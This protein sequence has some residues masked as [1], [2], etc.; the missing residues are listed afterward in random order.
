MLVLRNSCT[1]MYLFSLSLRIFKAFLVVELLSKSF[2]CISCVVRLSE[3]HIEFVFNGQFLF[4]S[5]IA[6]SK[7]KSVERVS[8]T[9]LEHDEN[10]ENDCELRESAP[11]HHGE[12]KAVVAAE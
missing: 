10:E 7:S 4:F 9:D 5:L 8:I 11:G 6:A 2:I 1:D 3:F 12:R